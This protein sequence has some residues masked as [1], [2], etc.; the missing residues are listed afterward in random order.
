MKLVIQIPCYNEEKTLPVIL[1]NLPRNVEGF[2][3]V[4]WLL[5]DDGSSDNSIQVA[6]QHNVDHILSLKI[7]KGLAKVFMEGLNHAV[8]L[9][10]D[11]IVNIDADNQ[12]SANDIPQIVQPILDK[13][14]D[15]VIGARPIDQI[16]HFSFIKK[17]LQKIGSFFVRKLSHTNIEDAPS[18]FRAFSKETA[19]KLN[20]FN[21]YTYTL[22]TI[23][24]AGIKNFSVVSI[25]IHTNPQLRPSRLIKS[26]FSYIRKSINTM[27]RISVIYNP[28]KFFM[29][30]GSAL[31]IIG[32]AL[33]V[34]F[35]VYYFLRNGTG[36]VQSLI[37]ASIMLGM[38]FQTVLVAFLA[39]LLFVNRNILEDIQY[40]IRRQDA[41]K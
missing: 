5:I 3:I 32:F 38:G 8:S 16:S 33:G 12:Y 39:D 23:I 22:E 30:I 31:F 20:V 1:G 13:K 2:S 15:M 28:F 34:R 10:A 7:N 4:E 18:G 35:L 11:V 26:I 21:Q 40:R 27:L 36:H 19:L 17:R 25:P 37:L 29:T 14:A 24:Q 41:E 6:E 9:G